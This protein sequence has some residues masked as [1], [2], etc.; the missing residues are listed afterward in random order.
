VDTPGGLFSAG[1]AHFAQGDCET[2]GTAIEM[3][4]TC[5]SPGRTTTCRPS[6]PPGAGSSPDIFVTG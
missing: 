6:S 4:A 1:D 2:C 3:A 5:G